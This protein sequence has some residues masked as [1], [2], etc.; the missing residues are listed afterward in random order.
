MDKKYEILKDQAITMNGSTIYRIKALRN[1]G[2]IKAGDIG[3]FIEKE[4]N[5]SHEGPC[6][7]YGDAMVYH[8]AKVR[9]NAIVR[10][11]A[12]VY[13]ESQVLHNAIVE[14]HARVCNNG[15]VFGNARIKDN[16]SV[17]DHGIVNGFAIVQDNAVV[18]DCARVYGETIIKDHATVAGYMMVSKGTISNSAILFGVGE[19]NFDVSSKD[20]WTFYRNPCIDSGF[21]TTS[22][23]IDVWNYRF[24]SGTAEEFIDMFERVDEHHRIPDELKFVKALVKF[25]QDLYFKA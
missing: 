23:K 4:E 22:T 25:H 17:F 16:G 20:D 19:I 2:D 18:R 11:Y 12:H 8:N 15:I 9:E 7:V 5:L 10:D 21:I 13:N 6:W 24:F 14:D 1:F 3:G